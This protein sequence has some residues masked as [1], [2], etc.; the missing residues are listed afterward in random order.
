MQ[1]LLLTHKTLLLLS[2]D[3]PIELIAS[4]NKMKALT[5]DESMVLQAIE[6]SSLLQV[7]PDHKCVCRSTPLPSLSEA[8]INSRTIYV[9]NLPNVINHDKLRN[10]FKS[11]G[12]V[13]YISLPRHKTSN[14]PKGFAFIEFSSSEEAQKAVQFFKKEETEETHPKKPE[15]T[16]N[17]SS[18]T[19]LED[20]V[21]TSNVETSDQS[22]V[23]ACKET[24]NAKRARDNDTEDELTTSESLCKKFKSESEAGGSMLDTSSELGVT[25][26]QPLPQTVMRI[27]SEV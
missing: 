8:D 11:F 27:D 20:N 23:G 1:Q 9:E 22:H 4:F 6:K 15:D 3:V 14:A 13:T 26:E 7:S 24:G 2:T 12:I 18:A 10:V 21:F 17:E 5:T 16:S 19:Q 25:N